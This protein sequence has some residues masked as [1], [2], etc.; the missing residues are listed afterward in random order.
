LSTFS[1]EQVEKQLKLVFELPEWAQIGFACR[2]GYSAEPVGDPIRVR[3]DIEQIC[4]HNRFGNRSL[5][6]QDGG[7][8][9]GTDILSFL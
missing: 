5:M 9:Y 7:A 1:N 2:L 4:H 6:F 3:R 8:Y